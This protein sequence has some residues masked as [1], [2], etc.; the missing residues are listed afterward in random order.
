[1][2]LKLLRALFRPI[3]VIS[4]M[5]PVFSADPVGDA[6]NE[7]SGAASFVKHLLTTAD[8]SAIEGRYAKAYELYKRALHFLELDRYRHS[9][10]LV[11]CLNKLSHICRDLVLLREGEV[12]ATRAVELGESLFEVDDEQLSAS[13]NNLGAIYQAQ[14]RY[15]EAEV[16][17]LRAL[18]MG[19]ASKRKP[20]A[21]VARTM[22]NLALVLSGRGRET[23]ALDMFGGA[24]EI[25][26]SLFGERHIEQYGIALS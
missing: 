3:S 6:A 7:D 14:D 16:L 19:R 10:A 8:A 21:I 1:M 17:Y 24:L 25:L 9:E 15:Q 20:D 23:E 18:G 5:G 4:E 2:A 13:L 11:L 12:Y 22:N 26:Q